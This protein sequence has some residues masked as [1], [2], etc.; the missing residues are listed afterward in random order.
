VLALVLGLLLLRLEAY[1]FAVATLAVGSFATVVMRN[2]TSVTNSDAGIIGL[3]YLP[4]PGL[5]AVQSVFFLGIIL[6]AFALYFQETLRT[7]SVG[8]A[9]LST[10]FDAPGSQA[11]GIG[12]AQSRIIAFAFS[13]ATAALGG[14]LMVQLTGGAFP[15]QFSITHS[16]SLLV[17]PIIGGRGWRWATI[18][19]ALVVIALPEYFRFLDEYRLVAYGVLVTLVALFVPGG[20]RQ[21]VTWMDTAW[22]RGVSHLRRKTTSTSGAPA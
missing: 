12:I 19:G 17:I 15:D 5:T 13:A 1:Y 16:I 18:V 14:A 20:A 4:V 9:L 7:S 22:R 21:L 10:R 3:G 2:W 6:L 11:L 8:L